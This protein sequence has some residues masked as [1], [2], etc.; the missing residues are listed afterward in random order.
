MTAEAGSSTTTESTASGNSS[1]GLHQQPDQV[2]NHPPAEG[3]V[4]QA[5]QPQPSPPS[6]SSSVPLHIPVP[7][8][9]FL[10]F[11]SL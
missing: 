3:V 5:S 4:I 7:P 10:K 2:M 8:Q 1:Q 6:P 11:F 9:A